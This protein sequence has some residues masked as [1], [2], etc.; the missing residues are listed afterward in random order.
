MPDSATFPEN[1]QHIKIAVSVELVSGVIAGEA[2]GHTGVV[3]LLQRGHA[4]SRRRAKS[5]HI[6]VLKPFV[7]Y[8]EGYNTYSCLTSSFEYAHE[9]C[10]RL[11][12]ERA[13]VTAHHLALEVVA[14]SSFR[15]VKYSL[16]NFVAVLIDVEVKV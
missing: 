13:T 2:N 6:S 1:L 14:D 10:R 11:R 15:D 3:E 9:F 12:S 4:S 8:R 16:G 7:H 5:T